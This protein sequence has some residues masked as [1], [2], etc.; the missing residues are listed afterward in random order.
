MEATLKEGAYAAATR[1]TR[2]R[3]ATYV[4]KFDIYL[5]TVTTAKISWET[6]IT[7]RKIERTVKII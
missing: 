7:I 4:E 5:K 3:S 6:L 1:T 2:R